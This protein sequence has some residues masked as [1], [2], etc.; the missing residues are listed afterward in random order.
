MIKLT[1]KGN[2]PVQLLDEKTLWEMKN[3]DQTVAAFQMYTGKDSKIIVSRLFR[4]NFMI[5]V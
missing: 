2:K 1:G 5:F 4:V 3:E